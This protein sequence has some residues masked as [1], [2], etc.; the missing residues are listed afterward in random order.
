MNIMS[1]VSGLISKAAGSTLLRRWPGFTMLCG[2]GGGG[3][4]PTFARWS[5]WLDSTIGF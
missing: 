4:D 2:G 5:L 1:T 3:P